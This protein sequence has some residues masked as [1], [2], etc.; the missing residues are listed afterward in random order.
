MMS[1]TAAFHRV[2]DDV[3]HRRAVVVR[4]VHA[5]AVR[6]FD[7]EDV[8]LAGRRGIGQHG[9]G[10]PAEIASKENRLAGRL[11]AHACVG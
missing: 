11:D 7:E 3:G 1:F 4:R 8:G 9:P 2:V 6:R 10:V 5:I